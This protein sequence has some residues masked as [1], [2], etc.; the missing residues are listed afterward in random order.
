MNSELR[1]V[2]RSVKNVF[3]VTD[4]YVF[5]SYARGEERPDRDLDLLVICSAIPDDP[6]DLTYEIRRYLH[7]RID[8]AIDVLVTTRIDFEHRRYQPWTVEYTAR[9]EGVVV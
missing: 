8:L 7:E 9:S 4:M 1:K 2:I 5:G 3:P 6:F